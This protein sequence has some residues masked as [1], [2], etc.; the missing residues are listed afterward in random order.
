MKT[1]LL[2]ICIVMI[3]IIKAEAGNK[4]DSSYYFISFFH[5]ITVPIAE[6]VMIAGAAACDTII[7]V[8]STTTQAQVM[9]SIMAERYAFYIASATQVKKEEY[10]FYKK[11]NTD[12]YVQD[13][14]RKEA[15]K[16]SYTIRYVQVDPSS[17]SMKAQGDFDITMENDVII[18]PSL[19]KLIRDDLV[20]SKSLVEESNVVIIEFRKNK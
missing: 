9:Q 19:K 14:E 1:K 15:C 20:K 5:H 10:V 2:V 8:P 6:W 11:G 13:K 3:S 12:Y 4:K 18:L 17:M 7:A 16:Y